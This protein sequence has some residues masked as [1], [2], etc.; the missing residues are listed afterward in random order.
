MESASK[1]RNK[2]ETIVKNLPARKKSPFSTSSDDDLE[3]KSNESDRSAEM[4]DSTT[5]S[6]N[7]EKKFD[8]EDE[9]KI[10]EK[11]TKTHV[12]KNIQS[13][14]KKKEQN[15]KNILGNI[16][17]DSKERNEDLSFEKNKKEKNISDKI[18][19]IKDDN[20]KNEQEKKIPPEEKNE[21]NNLDKKIFYSDK[22]N[23]LIAIFLEDNPGAKFLPEE[24]YTNEFYYF[25][26]SG[27]KVL[28]FYKEIQMYIEEYKKV[29]KNNSFSP[30]PVEIRD[31]V[32]ILNLLNL[33]NISFCYFY[34]KSEKNQKYE[35]IRKI[36]KDLYLL[37][38]F[39]T[40]LH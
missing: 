33:K 4:H 3:K 32:R 17:P 9:K 8:N 29:L 20:D 37:N 2:N 14:T 30:L 22:I 28:I 27:K 18:G 39:T 19:E 24:E 6:D 35:F 10:E 16:S 36:P 38:Y 34:V 23:K 26:I 40:N 7:L 21:D 1:S 12:A 13:V 31:H 5:N 15:P 11:K 25:E